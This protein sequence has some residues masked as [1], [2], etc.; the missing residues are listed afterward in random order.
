[1]TKA[2]L[3]SIGLSFL[4]LALLVVW[5]ATGNVREAR[6]EAPEAPPEQEKG[7]PS[8]QVDMLRDRPYEP[9]LMVQGQL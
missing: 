6:D 5:M 2:K 7:V 8:V 4:V 1:M 9:A 3:G